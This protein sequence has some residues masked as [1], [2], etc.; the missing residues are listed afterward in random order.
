MTNHR[1]RQHPAPGAATEQDVFEIHAREDRLFELVDGVLVEKESGVPESFL[2][3]L[4]GRRLGDFVDR[5]DL[6]FVL[7]A[8]GMS[9]LA[10]GL[11]RI[12]DVSFVSWRHF[13]SRR[14]PR[15]PALGFG[16]DLAIE[17]LSPSNTQK[18]M[19]RKLND[20][21]TAGVG[22]VW[23]VDPA[24]RTVQV[25]TASDARTVL[26]VDQTL[27]GDPILPGFALPIRSLFAQ[28][29]D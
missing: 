16:P 19:S 22:L 9:R 4:I 24:D 15:D 2:A 6:G 11:I 8:D 3:A 25:F 28:L 17:V 26:T 7:G 29:D 18:E 23:Y 10:P 12:P 20:Y 13:P 27:T 14:I 1:I 5:H 21:F